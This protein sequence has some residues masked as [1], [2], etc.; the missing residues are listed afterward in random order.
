MNELSQKILYQI[1]KINELFDYKD[2]YNDNMDFYD[3]KLFKL[4]KDFEIHDKKKE[5]EVK[6]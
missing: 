5:E 1:S 6:N 2:S 4:V 3:F